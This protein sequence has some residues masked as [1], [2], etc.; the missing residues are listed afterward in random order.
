LAANGGIAAGG[1]EGTGTPVRILHTT[2]GDPVIVL[3]DVESL[4]LAVAAAVVIEARRAVKRAGLFSIALSG[5]STPVRAYRLLAERPFVEQAPWPST[6]VF[7]GDERCVGPTD[8]RSN[9]RMARE[10]L[11]DHVPVPD[12]QIHPMRC[13]APASD[14]ARPGDTSAR[15]ARDAA[16]RY[17]TLLRAHGSVMDLVLLGIGE[18]GHTASLF[19]GLGA[20]HES[21]RWVLPA[22]QRSMGDGGGGGWAGPLWRVTLTPTYIN[23]AGAV[24]FLASGPEKAAI[25]KEAVSGEDSHSRASVRPLPFQLIRPTE[26]ALCWFVDGQAVSLLS[27]HGGA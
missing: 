26:G 3:P 17:E 9:E 1:G 23:Q 11:L 19:P 6:H 7:W 16:D 8:P 25:V 4:A 14:D 27:E 21:E 13:E 18:D 22:L 12:A 10:A 5:G 20:F 2:A 15:L 24:F